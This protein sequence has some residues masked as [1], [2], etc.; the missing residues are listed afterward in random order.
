MLLHV[1]EE[2]LLRAVPS[3]LLTALRNRW[4]S[5]P[6]EPQIRKQFHIIAQIEVFYC[7]ALV[8]IFAD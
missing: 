6:W 7:W 4:A 1:R 2:G 8:S 5:S 3:T